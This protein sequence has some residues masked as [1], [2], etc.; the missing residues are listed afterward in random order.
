MEDLDLLDSEEE[1]LIKPTGKV[2]N[3]S[4]I[5]VV[6]NALPF[7]ISLF[8]AFVG[9]DRGWLITERELGIFGSIVFGVALG[10][11][12]ISLRLHPQ[13][14]RG[15]KIAL[16]IISLLPALAFVILIVFAILD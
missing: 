6:I 7:L 5:G 13:K 2:H 10:F 8:F 11:A 3:F 14:H 1:T 9:S 16:T 12:V 15:G 4:I